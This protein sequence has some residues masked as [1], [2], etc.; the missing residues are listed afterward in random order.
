MVS[1]YIDPTSLPH[2]W[3]GAIQ[4]IF[5]AAVYGKVSD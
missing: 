4:L 3:G 2:D 5:L 1:I